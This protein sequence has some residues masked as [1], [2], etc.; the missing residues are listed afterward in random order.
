MVFSVSLLHSHSFSWQKNVES[1][2]AAFNVTELEILKE[3][4]TADSLAL[5]EEIT[6]LL[7]G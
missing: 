2:S 1:S 4:H 6:R 3:I 7:E 5:S